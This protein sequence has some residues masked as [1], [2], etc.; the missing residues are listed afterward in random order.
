MVVPVGDGSP[1]R[2]RERRRRAV[3]AAVACL[4]AGTGCQGAANRAQ[5]PAN[6]FLDPSF[7]ERG[8]ESAAFVA[9]HSVAAD[10]Q[11]PLL[12]GGLFSQSLRS[13]QNR[14]VVLDPETASSVASRSGHGEAFRKVKEIWESHHR[15]DPAYA[16]ELC[17][18]LAV[19]GLLMA[20]ITTWEREKVDWTSEGR[21]FTQVTLSLRL[22]DGADGRLVWN[23]RE[24]RYEE[25]ERYEFS[26]SQ[27][28]VYTDDSR[29]SR[30]EQPGGVAP[31]PPAYEEVARKIVDVLV[32]SL[33]RLER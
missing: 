6:V 21:S 14:F 15:V 13:Q 31:E 29:V 27:A 17:K 16:D 4:I 22:V 3:A 5:G 25:S 28:G 1:G 24:S 7:A 11:A 20:D 10:D 2:A 9:V 18:A 32:G 23:G 19:D 30:V 12:V 8:I 33:G 26:E